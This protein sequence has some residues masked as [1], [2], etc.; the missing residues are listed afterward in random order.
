MTGDIKTNPDAD[1]LIMTT[2]ILMNYLY[3]LGSSVNS[4][5]LQF[6]IDIQNELRELLITKGFPS[7][8]SAVGYAHREGQ[9]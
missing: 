5:T 4:S 6:Q 2:E 9:L 8:K 3:S 7:L 1:V